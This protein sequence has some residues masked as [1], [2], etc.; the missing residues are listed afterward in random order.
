[1]TDTLT[2][3]V[4][5]IATTTRYPQHLLAAEADLERDLGI[6][7]VKR[8]EIVIAL[9]QRFGLDLQTEVRDPAI[10]TIR[11]VAAWVDRHLQIET[12]KPI[13]Q[14]T[15]TSPLLTTGKSIQQSHADAL[16][17]RPHLRVAPENR[18][19]RHD[20]VVFIT[21][22]GR[23]LGKSIACSL[24]AR[25]DTVI[26]NSFHSRDE[27]ERTV[28][29]ITEHGGEA[30]HLWGSVANADHVDA[31]FSQIQERFGRLDALI[32]N[33]SDGRLGSFLDL[34]I[35]DWSRAFQTNISGHYQ[36]ALR[37][38]R[39]MHPIGGGAIITLS[40]VGAHHHVD[41]LGSQGVVKAAVESLTKYLA[42]ELAAYGVRVNCV[43]GGPVYGE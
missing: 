27:G 16:P 37:A 29:S 3:V 42:V 23:G 18:R 14:E 22:S 32:C 28:E 30:F 21:G 24:A 2:Q 19:A 17:A 43:V 15:S 7:S 9:G 1:M 5:C 40:A 10:S 33:A 25:G 6:D 39:L 8:V 20:R 31:M 12:T 38:A 11:D 36:C 34:S 4:E 26:V 41:G 35:D 13:K